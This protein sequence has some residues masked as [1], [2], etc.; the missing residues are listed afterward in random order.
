[1]RLKGFA[2]NP[3]ILYRQNSAKCLVRSCL[4]IFPYAAHGLLQ[5]ML[6]SPSAQ[7]ILW[8]GKVPVQDCLQ[9]THVF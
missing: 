2:H 4:T 5:W 8:A 6:G 1:M 3:I 9:L 7:T